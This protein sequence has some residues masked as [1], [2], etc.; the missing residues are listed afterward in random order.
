MYINIKIN[1]HIYK[2]KYYGRIEVFPDVE[3]LYITTIYDVIT[4]LC[5]LISYHVVKKHLSG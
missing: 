5:T 1:G 4:Y 3:L 2:A